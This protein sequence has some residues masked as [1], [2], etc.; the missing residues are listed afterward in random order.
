LRLFRDYLFIFTISIVA[1]LIP[2]ILAKQ[3]QIDLRL[4][5][6]STWIV[7]F[8]SLFLILNYFES[9]QR[10]ISQ[11]FFVSLVV[12]ATLLAFTSVQTISSEIR[13]IYTT[14]RTFLASQI[15]GCSTE[16]LLTGVFI[17]QRTTPWPMKSKIGVFSQVTD[18]S[19][20]W[21][22]IGAVKLLLAEKDIYPK[23]ISITS[24]RYD[25]GISCVV[26]LNS[27][28]LDSEKGRMS[29]KSSNK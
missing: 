23:S 21:V 7:V 8:S 20:D 4:I 22:P 9:D 27:F 29:D 12:V 13:S 19:S 18:L 1:S 16:Q 6:S 28:S 14:N 26:D 2:L 11:N 25:D 10:P 5:S 15:N 17:H 3:N 24:K